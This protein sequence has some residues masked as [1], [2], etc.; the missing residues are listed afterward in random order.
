MD[1]A[2]KGG[3]SILFPFIHFID[4]NNYKMEDSKSLIIWKLTLKTSSAGFDIIKLLLQCLEHIMYI[5]NLYL[6]EWRNK[7][8]CLSNCRQIA[9]PTFGGATTW[10]CLRNETQLT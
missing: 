6:N 10:L 7:W 2:L 4:N 5:I 9:R 3:K 1:G 8:I